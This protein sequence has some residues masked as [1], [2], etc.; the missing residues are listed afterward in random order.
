MSRMS[1]LYPRGPINLGPALKPL[2]ADRSVPAMPGWRWI[3]TP[4]HSVG[5]VSFWR[6][7]DR[8]LIAGDAVVTTAQESVLAVAG[9]R[10]EMHGPPMYYT[11]DWDAAKRSVIEISTLEPEVLVSGHGIAMRGPQMRAAL[12]RLAEDFDAVARPRSGIYLERPAQI[13][14]RS[15]YRTP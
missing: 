4:G 10:A 2:P 6:E 15:A 1:R 11:V 5:H 7:S 14:D 12:R 13:R 8:V 3:E 9:Q